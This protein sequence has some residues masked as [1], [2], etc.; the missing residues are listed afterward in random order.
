MLQTLL[1]RFQKPELTGVTCEWCGWHG[2]ASDIIKA[3]VQN[4]DSSQY[5]IDTCPQ[6]LRNGKLIYHDAKTQ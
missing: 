3:V 5:R 4:E 6:C 2:E 1:K